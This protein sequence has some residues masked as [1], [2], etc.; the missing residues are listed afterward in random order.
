MTFRPLAILVSAY[1][2]T[3]SG[4]AAQ[5]QSPVQMSVLPAGRSAAPNE[6][7]TFLATIVN[8]SELAM[9]CQPRFGG[10]VPLSG[11]AVAQ[12]RFFTLDGTDVGGT[13]NGSVNIP[14][15]GRQDYVVVISVNRETSGGISVPVRCTDENDLISDIPRLP[16][17][18]EFRVRI[19]PG[20][21]ADV[22]MIGDTLSRDGVARAGETGPRTLLMTVAAV[23]IGEAGTNLVV[24][25]DLTGFSLL[26]QNLPPQICEIDAQGACLSAEGNSV[27]VGNWANNE[28][29]LFAVRV[30]M[31]EQVGIPFYPDLLRLRVGVDAAGVAAADATFSTSVATDGHARQGESFLAPVQ[32][33]ATQPAG[34][35]GYGFARQGGVISLRQP[36]SPDGRFEA[37]GYLHI[38]QLQLESRLSD[39]LAIALEGALTEDGGTLTALGTGEAGIQQTDL[40][41]EVTIANDTAGALR[42]SWP[43]G[44][45][46]THDL[47]QAGRTRCVPVPPEETVEAPVARITPDEPELAFEHVEDCDLPHRLCGQYNVSRFARDGENTPVP[48]L[49]DDK[50]FRR[51]WG[52]PAERDE[53]VANAFAEFFRTLASTGRNDRVCQSLRTG[54]IIDAGQVVPH[55]PVGGVGQQQENLSSPASSHD[56]AAECI[57]VMLREDIVEGAVDCDDGDDAVLAVFVRSDS[58]LTPQ[59]CIP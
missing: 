5:A 50:T 36:V 37:D 52:D 19:A 12:A 23:N 2:V 4:F 18:N 25:P 27:S 16:L 48:G 14:A 51:N 41:V 29:R 42:I 6:D 43:G 33:C 10:F 3:L 54:A 31:P 8:S 1:L 38:S 26:N 20:N 17:V 30:R 7:V 24:T 15:G 55:V 46:V 45:P 35:V 9:T 53:V 56:G 47:S 58:D 11:G 57:V 59:Q 39:Y 21:Q 34:D 49:S 22:I 32:Q 44:A 13:A 40:P 28:I